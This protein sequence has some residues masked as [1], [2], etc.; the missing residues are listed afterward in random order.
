M[1]M[2]VIIAIPT[3]F[4][5]CVLMSEVTPLTAEGLVLVPI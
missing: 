5:S 4:W 2:A 1:A 3:K